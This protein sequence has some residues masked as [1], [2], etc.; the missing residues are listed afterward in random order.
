MKTGGEGIRNKVAV[1]ILTV[2]M[3]LLH[4]GA[5]CS[6]LQKYGVIDSKGRWIIPPTHQYIA[7][8]GDGLYIATEFEYGSV[9]YPMRAAVLDYQGRPVS[10]PLPDG[11]HVR[12]ILSNMNKPV[13][14]RSDILLVIR[15][16]QKEGVCDIA[17]KIIIAP[18]Y[19]SIKTYSEGYFTAIDDQKTVFL[20]REGQ[21]LGSVS[22]WDF[23][24]TANDFHE[25]VIVG[26]SRNRV[27]CGCK[28]FRP[29]GSQLDLPFPLLSS[30]SQFSEGYAGVIVGI[31]GNGSFATL[32]NKKGELLANK[33]F[34]CVQSFQSG[35]AIAVVA[36][37]P[38]HQ[39][40]FGVVDHSGNF[41]IPAIYDGLMVN[42]D[43]T[44]IA[45]LSSKGD[46]LIDRAGRA[47]CEYHEKLELFRSDTPLLMCVIRDRAALPT[48]TGY[49]AYADRHGHIFDVTQWPVANVVAPAWTVES[50][51]AWEG[52]RSRKSWVTPT[53][54][55]CFQQLPEDRWIAIYSSK[56]S[57]RHD[58]EM[59]LD[60]MDLFQN[61]LASQNLIGMPRSRLTELLGTD[62]SGP[63]WIRF[64]CGS[65]CS[66]GATGILIQFAGERVRRWRVS[67][68]IS[69]T[70]S[71]LSDQRDWFSKDVVFVDNRYVQKVQAVRHRNKRQ[72]R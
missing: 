11:Y 38:H 30:A 56:I 43:Q 24:F 66:H 45:T 13:Q 23:D 64:K 50:G 27:N 20:N 29:D 34:E 31:F 15:N 68:V 28:F 14:S 32:I 35:Q 49:M 46:F 53:R 26:Q 33:K 16:G 8:L 3:L 57:D 65:G 4:S 63:D 71:E 58:W 19:E 51:T 18:I 37:G 1:V 69:A 39:R 22:T 21:V 6:A 72:G 54:F 48:Y 52:L 12:G 44:Y 55:R 2:A 25:G 62:E 17:G 41:V 7:W 47:V 5:P 36:T 67:D 10:I 40:K 70:A 59:N 61:L 42:D 60:R 9:I